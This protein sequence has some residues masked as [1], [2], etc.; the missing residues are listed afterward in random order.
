MIT[1]DSRGTKIVRLALLVTLFSISCTLNAL[2]GFGHE[3]Y[4]LN[5]EIST[6]GKQNSG[7]IVTTKRQFVV[8]SAKEVCLSG[9]V[10]S[11]G[12]ESFHIAGKD[13]DR[14]TIETSLESGEEPLGANAK[15]L[16]DHLV[17]QGP[18][19]PNMPPLYQ[20]QTISSMPFAIYFSSGSSHIDASQVLGG[21]TSYSNEFG[22]LLVERDAHMVQ[23]IRFEKNEQHLISADSRIKLEDF[24]SK[25]C[26]KGMKRILSTVI[27]DPYLSLQ[28]PVA[29]RANITIERIPLS[30]D[31]AATHDESFISVS[32]FQVGEQP[33]R[34]YVKSILSSIPDGMSVVR[35]GAVHYEWRSGKKIAAVDFSALEAGKEMTFK[36]SRWS[37][38]WIL[39]VS[40][41]A[42]VILS[43]SV[44]AFQKLVR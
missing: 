18:F 33:A 40:L 42:L 20:S 32:S 22:T 8:A 30:I 36:G 31:E 19:D 16:V 4:F 24:R 17:E 37:V 39:T 27:F 44:L 41:T 9:I 28:D 1:Q 3:Y 5:G 11:D 29:W 26:Q 25:F 6:T 10:T 23:S 21:G 12:H 43:L 13:F 7:K 35:K 34:N 15:R 38:N 2:R 14:L